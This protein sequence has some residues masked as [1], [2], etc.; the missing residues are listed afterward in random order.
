VTDWMKEKSGQE[1]LEAESRFRIWCESS[2]NTLYDP[3][4]EM[5]INDHID[6]IIYN[7]KGDRYTVDIKGLKR[8]GRSGNR[9][10]EWTWVE[11]ANVQGKRGWLYGKAD[12][13]I[14]EHQ[15]GWIYVKSDDLKGFAER[16]IKRD[17]FAE[18]PQ[19]AKYRIYQREGRQ[20]EI[21]LVEL[22]ELIKIGKFINDKK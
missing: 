18:T 21:A 4:N 6:F 5:N 8:V 20:D 2:G 9:Q 16:R 22:K 1:G 7:K 12:Y 15:N 11:F 3:P 14:F 10:S 17:Y 13:I 19:A